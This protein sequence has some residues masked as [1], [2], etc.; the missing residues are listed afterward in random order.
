MAKRK[1]GLPIDIKRAAIAIRSRFAHLRSFFSGLSSAPNAKRYFI[2]APILVFVFIIV[3]FPLDVFIVREL[4]SMEGIYFKTIKTEDLSISPFSDWTAKSILI[5]TVQKSDIG[6]S[7]VDVSLGTISLLSKKLSGDISIGNFTFIAE[8]VQMTSAVTAESDVALDEMSLPMNGTFSLNLANAS[9][10]GLTMQGFKI[11]PVQIPK[12]KLSG[13]FSGKT[14]TIKECSITGKDL[15]GTIKGN[16]TI[17]RI[18]SRT[19]LN[20]TIEIDSN[21]NMLADYKPLLG[22]F[23]NQSNGR[24]QISVQGTTGTPSVNMVS[25]GG[26]PVAPSF[27]R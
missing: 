3:T 27:K 4:K 15:S 11:P 6:F 10:K 21:S 9:I 17:D 13:V 7:D 19:Q 23:I 24:L 14:M 1:K 18:F 2:A 5:T 20:L 8:D 26:S 12:A 16:V 22:S 25:Q